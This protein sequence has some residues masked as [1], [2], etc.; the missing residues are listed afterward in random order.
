MSDTPT[1]TPLLP[2]DQRTADP[3]HGLGGLARLQADQRRRWLRGERRLVEEYRTGEF[4]DLLDDVDHLLDLIYHEV[5]LREELGDTPG[6]GEYQ[7]RFP[8]LAQ[9][10]ADLFEVHASLKEAEWPADDND[11]PARDREAVTLWDAPDDA[12]RPG[13]AFPGYELIR[14][15]GRG[16]MGVVYLARQHGLGRLVAVKLLMA[17]AGAHS[18]DGD[19]LRNEAEAVARLDHPNLVRIYEVG[20]WNG[21]PFLSMEYVDGQRLSDALRGTQIPARRAAELTATLARACHSAHERG[22]VH[23]DLTPNNVL[24]VTDGQPKIVDFGLSK[25]VTGGAGT[26]ETLSGDVLGTP[27]YMAPEQADGRSKD[28]GPTADIYALGAILYHMLT[29]RPPFQAETALETLAQVAH[30]EPVTPRRLQASVSRDLETICLKCLSKEPARRYPSALALADDLAR[31]LAG[32]PVRARPLGAAGRVARWVRRRPGMAAVLALSALGAALAVGLIA[33]E[34]RRARHAQAGAEIARALEQHARIAAQ[35]AQT[36]EAAQRKSYQALSAALVRD[37]ALLHCEQGDVGQG[38]LWLAQ[39]LTLVPDDDRPLAQ[40]IRSNLAGWWGATHPLHGLLGHP[41]RVLSAVWSPDGSRVLTACADRTARLWDAKTG[42]ARGAPLVHPRPVSAAAFSPNGYTLLTVAGPE[43]RLWNTDAEANANAG[44]GAPA[45]PRII[46]LGTGGEL[47][48]H[49]FSPDGQRL[50]T[51]VRRG[52]DAWLQC[53]QTTTAAPRGAPLALGRGVTVAVFSPDG[54]AL[55]TAGSARTVPAYLWTTETDPPAR[56]RELGEYAQ[57][58]SAV[59][60]S[61]KDPEVFV[62]GSLDRTCFV[63]NVSPGTPVRGPFRLPGQIRAVALSP[64]GRTMLAGASDGAAQFWDI[65]R[66]VPLYAPLPHPDAVSAVAFSADGRHACS[67]S[68]DLVWLWDATTGEAL[69]APAPHPKEV[70]TALF[71]PDGRTFL[72]RG[73]DFS[74][75]IWQ[76]APARPAGARL[77]H[78]GWVTA[79]AFRPPGGDS[80]LTAVGGSDG[81]VRS[82][83]TA[84]P[85]MPTDL[86]Q[87][88]GP[89]LSLACSGDGRMFAAGSVGREVRLLSASAAGAGASSHRALRLA[90]RVWSLAFSPDGRTLLTGIEKRKAEFWDVATGALKPPAIEH[91]RAVYAVAFSPDGRWVATGSEDMTAQVWDAV[92]RRPRGRRLQHHGTV[93]A[94]AFRPP[95]GRVILTASGD[96]TAQLWDAASGEPLGDP[97]Q[98]PAR[99]LAVAFSPD[100]ALFATGCGD[101]MARLW[102]AQSGHP[103][104]RPVRHHRPVR[105]LAFGPRPKPRPGPGNSAPPAPDDGRWVLL[106]G[107][108]DLS[109]RLT[110]VPAPLTAPQEQIRR[111]LEVTHGM[112]LDPHG[113]A[114]ALAPEPW[115]ARRSAAGRDDFGLFL[116]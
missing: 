34:G 14:E 65:E 10:L 30:E 88:T 18:R 48:A 35:Q 69:G 1:P 67:V 26:G 16:G 72:T 86:L 94:L 89:L 40:A 36:R 91:E 22:V 58:I 59:A 95:D 33:W 62:T 42:A 32:Q 112:T 52:A 56:V 83:E 76:T 44:T 55:V 31:H 12:P 20:A 37:R 66:G 61:P 80:F 47:A 25:L 107:S 114:E 93:Y 74:V 103:L 50:A 111:M 96:R 27:S 116:P 90:D 108:E 4:A 21:R 2:H 60:F 79:V 92:T 13:T 98:H 105:A 99:V 84:V 9:G 38:L 70:V 8:S 71:A 113:M 75:R 6:L 5:M 54:A 106:T 7:E 85:S 39:S 41:D 87:N 73:R 57:R 49:A 109:A 78:N 43:I 110:D 81:R 63:W 3:R 77:A 68:W 24:I 23:R 64:D 102:D 115:N 19:R 45:I 51:V 28:V 101:G 100:G 82:W 15:L 29:G 104:G 53:W 17:T 46:N 11:A 97:I